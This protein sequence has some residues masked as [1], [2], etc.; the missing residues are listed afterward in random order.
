MWQKTKNPFTSWQ[1]GFNNKTQDGQK[2]LREGYQT[3]SETQLKQR[4]QERDISGT[5]VQELPYH[6]FTPYGAENADLRNLALV[7]A[8]TQ[9]NIIDFTNPV[10]A[11]L[12]FIGYTVF[13]DALTFAN[14]EFRPTV[15][16]KRIL[17]FHGNP[18]TLNSPNQPAF[19]I[20]LG[21]SS[22]FA[23]LVPCQVGLNP[24]ERLLWTIINNEAVDQVFGVR[25]SGYVD[26]TGSRTNTR[27]GG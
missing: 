12:F 5:K 18:N 14:I 20:G 10:G 16:G 2:A 23:T 21:V 9:F 6:L 27:F 7:P 25:M 13:T 8:G 19:K 24:G 4:S 11:K 1:H 22:D 3:P 17:P 15:N 26:T